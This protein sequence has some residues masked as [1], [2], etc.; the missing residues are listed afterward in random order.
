[1]GLRVG[2][3]D[4]INQ[5]INLLR[6]TPDNEKSLVFS[7]FTSFLDKVNIKLLLVRDNE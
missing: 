5:L 2:P 7:Q 4:K 6:L 3:S 1:V